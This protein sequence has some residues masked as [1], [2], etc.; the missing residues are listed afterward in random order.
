MLGR[1]TGGP[2]LSGVSPNVRVW[3]NVNPLGGNGTAFV[4]AEQAQQVGT[5]QLTDRNNLAVWFCDKLARKRFDSVDLTLVARASSGIQLWAP[6]EATFTM[7]Q[8]CVDVW[9]ATGQ[10]PADVFIWHQGENN[11]A[12]FVP[13]YQLA[14]ET[15]V[16]NLKAGGIISDST[17]IIVGGILDADSTRHTFNRKALMP[18]GNKPG[19]AFARSYGLTSSDD[20]HF[21]G[22]SLVALGA[23]RYFSAY[24]F[25]S[26]A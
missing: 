11:V 6:T 8:E 1:G 25:A 20:A 13:S 26:R 7:L 17:I 22:A 24:L 9:A 14:F 23:L 4:T 19:R 5:F 2:S 3:N 15:L 12:T 16:D 18:L 10:G 21:D